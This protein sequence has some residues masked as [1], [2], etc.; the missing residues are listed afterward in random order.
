MQR[1]R[2][3]AILTL[4]QL[5][6][7]VPMPPSCLFID[8]VMRDTPSNLVLVSGGRARV[9][10]GH[11]CELATVWSGECCDHQSCAMVASI[12]CRTFLFAII[13]QLSKMIVNNKADVIIMNP[14]VGI[15]ILISLAI[16]CSVSMCMGLRVARNRR[17]CIRIPVANKYNF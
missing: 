14:R 3:V 2:F 4:F 6:L 12:F 16:I 7:F 8:K 17:A 13:R 15:T 1:H 5:R 9:N 10:S 11:L